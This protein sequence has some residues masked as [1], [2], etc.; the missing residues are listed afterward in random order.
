MAHTLRY[1]HLLLSLAVKSQPWFAENWQYVIYTI[2]TQDNILPAYMEQDE[3]IGCAMGGC[4]CVSF[5]VRVSLF[6]IP[7]IVCCVCV[8]KKEKHGYT[9]THTY[10]CTHEIITIHTFTAC[11][12]QESFFHHIHHREQ[13]DRVKTSRN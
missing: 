12:C 5:F 2:V 11:S 1:T 13:G 8:V 9:H 4:V 7:A 10:I 6:Q 3:H